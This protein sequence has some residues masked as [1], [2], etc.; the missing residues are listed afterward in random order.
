VTKSTKALDAALAR[1]PNR[2]RRTV[3]AEPDQKKVQ[4]ALGAMSRLKQTFKQGENRYGEYGRNTQAAYERWAKTYKEL[5]GK[6]APHIYDS[7]GGSG[8]D[9]AL[10]LIPDR[11]RSRTF[12]L[13][14]GLDAVLARTSRGRDEGPHGSLSESEKAAAGREG[15]EHR[16]NEPE[17]VFLEPGEKKYPVKVK[18]DG[19]WK[20]DRGLLVAA[21]REARMHGHEALAKRAD[22]IRSKEFGGASDKL[23]AALRM[24][25]DRR[26]ARDAGLQSSYN[27]G[28]WTITEKRNGLWEVSARRGETYVKTSQAEA[29]AF[30]KLY[31]SGKVGL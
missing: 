10:R 14:S 22:A 30:A 26:R 28:L 23:D 19:E 25:P 6:E 21:A 16:E 11:R 3:D 24:I 4:E 27:I 20:Y 12:G 5:T 17:G 9:A 29:E 13:R 8:L 7:A 15:S 31:P 2:R 1:I 18:R